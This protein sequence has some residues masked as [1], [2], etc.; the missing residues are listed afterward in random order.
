VATWWLVSYVVLWVVVI[1]QAIL[2]VEVLREIGMVRQASRAR[3][4]LSFP[5]PQ[6]DGPPLGSRAPEFTA[7]T[8]NGYGSAASVL[9][10]PGQRMLLVFLSPT[11]EGCQLVAEALNVLAAQ[12]ANRLAILVIMRSGPEAAVRAF[13]NLFR[14]HV[15]VILDSGD[16]IT[17]DLHVH[18]APFGLLYDSGG[19][20]ARRGLVKTEDDL[21]ALLGEC[22]VPEEALAN[23]YPRPG[24]DSRGEQARATLPLAN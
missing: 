1:V 19:Q 9:A 7:E 24:A 20:L 8:I 6:E 18:H 3:A 22:S 2:I 11:C 14:L 13:L 23:V 15:P 21:A 5:S 10:A 12:E 17:T 16:A 4:R